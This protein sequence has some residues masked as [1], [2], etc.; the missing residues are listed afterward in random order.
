MIQRNIL[1]RKCS[2]Q[3]PSE[4]KQTTCS[5]TGNKKLQIRQN[6][7]QQISGFYSQVEEIGL[8]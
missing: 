1:L 7:D 8:V 6:Q 3:R 2:P 5:R 4:V